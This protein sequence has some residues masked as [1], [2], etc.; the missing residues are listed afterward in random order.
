M[1]VMGFQTKFGWRAGGF[2]VGGCDGLY[3]VLLGFLDFCYFAKA[4]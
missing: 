1:S 4:P 3:P 2:W